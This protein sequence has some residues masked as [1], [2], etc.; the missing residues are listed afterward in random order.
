MLGWGFLVRGP[1]ELLIPVGPRL[2]IPL[3]DMV[4]TSIGKSQNH[5]WVH[6]VGLMVAPKTFI[7]PEPQNMALA[8]GMEVRLSR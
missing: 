8:D 2:S 6:K 1:W 5:P 4:A 7:F 3:E